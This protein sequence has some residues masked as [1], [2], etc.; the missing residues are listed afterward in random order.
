[1]YYKISKYILLQDYSRET[2][3]LKLMSLDLMINKNK[4]LMDKNYVMMVINLTNLIFHIIMD[5][6][7]S[8]M[9]IMSTK[10]E[11]SGNNNL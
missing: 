1:M 11:S 4:K 2:K 6:K 7:T 8:K 10:M 5:M 9:R 3:K